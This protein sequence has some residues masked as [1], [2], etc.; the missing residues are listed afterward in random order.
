MYR[1]PK[2]TERALT[3]SVVINQKALNEQSHKSPAV[4][5]ATG[6]PITRLFVGLHPDQSYRFTCKPIVPI[7]RLLP[8]LI[9]KQII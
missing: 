1:V 8:S 9:H 4:C 5:N 3:L 6:S 2:C 7:K